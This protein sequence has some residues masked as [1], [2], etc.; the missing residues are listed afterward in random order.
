MTVGSYDVR[1]D[2]DA[3]RGLF[4]RSQ[5]GSPHDLTDG[6]ASA[7]NVVVLVL[8]YGTSPAGGGPRPRHSVP[9]S[10]RLHGRAQDRGHVEPHNPTDPFA[11][12]A[13]GQPILLAPGRTWVALVDEQHNLGDD[14]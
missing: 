14:G 10:R 6:Q 7:D 5:L 1:W 2:W 11:L 9:G 8:D 3:V 12:E 4:L 13:N